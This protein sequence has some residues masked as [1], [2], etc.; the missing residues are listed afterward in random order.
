MGTYPVYP[1]KDIVEAAASAAGRSADARDEEERA[2]ATSEESVCKAGQGPVDFVPGSDDEDLD[3]AD[4]DG[5]DWDDDELD[6]IEWEY[7]S[8]DEAWEGLDDSECYEYFEVG[9]GDED[10]GAGEAEGGGNGEAPAGAE[11]AADEERDAG[12]PAPLSSEELESLRAAMGEPAAGEPGRGEPA[13]ATSAPATSVPAAATPVSSQGATRRRDEPPRALIAEVEPESPAWEVGFEPGC[14]ITSVDGQPVRDLIDW[15]WLTDDYVIDVGYIDL[16]GDTGVVTM[17]RDEGEPWGIEF[18]GVVFDGVKQCRNACTFCFM[19]QLPDDMRPS[20]TLRDDDF[21]LSFLAGTFVTF[22][23]ISAE[24]EARIIEQQISPLRFSLH[25]ANP[26]VRRRMIGK[27]AAHGL[28]VADRLLDAG[29]EMR[30]QIVL[31]PGENDG[32]ILAD[33]LRWCWARPG[34][35]D[36]CI[37]PLGYTKHQQGFEHSYNEPPQARAVLD[38]VRP[39]QDRAMAERGTLWAY[40]SDE[41]YHSAYGHELLDNLPPSEAYGEFEMFEDGVGII[42]SFVDDWDLAEKQGSIGRCAAALEEKGVRAYYIAGCAM[43]DILDVLVER[44]PLAG[45]LV[46]LFVKNDY[47]GGNVDV[48]GLL[49]GCDITAAVNEVVAERGSIAP[50]VAVVEV[51]EEGLEVEEQP[52]AALGGA[53]PS[54]PDLLFLIPEVLLNDDGITLD[55]MSFE[56]MERAVDARL[57]VVSCNASEYLEEIIEL[58]TK[59]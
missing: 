10:D 29:I 54:D 45:H 6:G 40:P 44:S 46:P 31:V 1:S 33:T 38:T 32:E 15:R 52:T 57:A 50:D 58:V 49:C 2:G 8:D 47:F 14:Y 19:R 37:V 4:W 55:D 56:D 26:E 3:D 23:N 43:R 28:E 53:E 11:C 16:D 13:P 17:E 7:A 12:A 30:V 39:F 42:R 20:L 24:D 18:D 36:V 51:D 22:T 48:T 5:E 27:H 59:Q 41:L 21:R 34:I 35:L 9:E 25:V